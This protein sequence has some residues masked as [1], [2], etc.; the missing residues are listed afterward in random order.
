MLAVASPHAA[1]ALGVLG[2]VTVKI[3]GYQGWTQMRDTDLE[4]RFSSIISSTRKGGVFEIPE[5]GI[6]ANRFGTSGA[7][8]VDDE[9]ANFVR[10]LVGRSKL[11][12]PIDWRG[13][14]RDG[15]IVLHPVECDV[16]VRGMAS[17]I[18]TSGNLDEAEL[19]M[20]RM[21]RLPIP[22]RLMK[23]EILPLA[24]PQPQPPPA[25]VV[26]RDGAPPRPVAPVEPAIVGPI[27][28]P[29]AP[30]VPSVPTLGVPAADDVVEPLE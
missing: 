13:E 28:E 20:R 6:F 1:A 19:K 14:I 15:M 30:T 24:T 17:C 22:D 8:V 9:A 11:T 21:A 10:F 3:D 12:I 23:P 5:I 7:V 26:E 16:D 4:V 18:S 27:D 2:Q 25:A 29:G